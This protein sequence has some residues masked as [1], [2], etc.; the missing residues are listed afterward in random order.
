M[1]AGGLGALGGLGG[2]FGAFFRAL[3]CGDGPIKT[4]FWK[5]PTFHH[6]D[7]LG[8]TE[9]MMTDEFWEVLARPPPLLCKRC[10]CNTARHCKDG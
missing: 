2:V 8:S 5:T 6:A 1:G 7:D 10:S 3:L 4:H 9:P